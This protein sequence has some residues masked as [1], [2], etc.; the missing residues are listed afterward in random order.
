MWYIYIYICYIPILVSNL[1]LYYDLNQ[2]ILENL[3]DR[4][5]WKFRWTVLEGNKSEI[6]KLQKSAVDCV[7]IDLY[8]GIKKLK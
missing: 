4:I 5:I 6:S 3:T 8:L 2:K 7:C 1:P